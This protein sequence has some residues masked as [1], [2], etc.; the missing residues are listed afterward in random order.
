ME[1]PVTQVHT[2]W[3]ALVGGPDLKDF[4]KD[5]TKDYIYNEVTDDYNAGFC[6]DL[7]G[8]Y[9]FY[10]AK[11]KELED[12]NYVIP[13]FDMS[14]NA[15]GYDQVD[16]DGNPIPTGLFISAGKAQETDAG[17]QIKI[18]LHNRTINPP[19]FESNLKARYY[20]NIGE[21]IAKGEDISFIETR[22]DY[23]QEKSFTNGQNQALIS[24]P[25]K[26]D[27]N[28]TYYVEISWQNCNFYGSRVY[29]FGLL[30][31]MNPET[32][33]T[34]WDSSNDY[35]YDDLISFEGD[36]DAAAIT[37][38]ITLYADDK[39]VWGV[40]P[41]GT[42]PS[43]EPSGKIMYGDSNCDNNVDISDAV[44]IMQALA[45][46]DAYGLGGTDPTAITVQGL[47]NADCETPG[48]GVTNQDALAIQKLCIH[49][50][51]SLPI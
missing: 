14:A 10:G 42:K 32:Y 38:K 13:D 39:L 41:D 16:A 19:K 34:V 49:L 25:V 11:G 8:L 23:D 6:G 26:Y 51:D 2:L 22:I 44:L 1:D 18:V 29:Q 17:L 24:E 27:D 28:G 40:E 12:K 5:E 48:S 36:N 50:I 21:Q 4:H 37:E 9:H 46:P 31:K 7:A 33:D 45:N 20:F 15:V 47:K 30:N 3:G 35:S 43:D